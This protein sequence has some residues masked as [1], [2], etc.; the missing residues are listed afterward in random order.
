MSLTTSSLRWKRPSIEPRLLPVQVAIGAP[1]FLL[2]PA[3]FLWLSWK[4]ATVG[5]TQ[6]L[7]P[8][9]LT[10]YAAGEVVF[11]LYLLFRWYTQR[12]V[13]SGLGPRLSVNELTTLLE[14]IFA[15]PCLGTE[16]HDAVQD[17][18]VGALDD[19]PA[20]FRDRFR[21]WFLN[22]PFDKIRRGN[23]ADWLAW[24]AFNTHPPDVT[25][26]QTAVI[27]SL[28]GMF[29]K[30]CRR[31]FPS[32]QNPKVRS[33]R[34]TLDP[35][36]FLPRP[37]LFYAVVWLF[38]MQM[39][40]S[41]LRAGWRHHRIEAEGNTFSYW[42]YAPVLADG[43]TRRRPL[44][45]LHG[46]GLGLAQYGSFLTSLRDDHPDREI[47]ALVQGQVGMSPAHRHWC[48]PPTMSQTCAAI[49]RL[50]ERHD[51]H[52]VGATVLSHSFG[53]ITHAWLL[54]D[55][56]TR[57]L[58]RKNVMVDPICFRLWEAD[59]CYNF[60]YRKPQT[61]TQYLTLA[62]VARELG[63]ST[64]MYRSF[65]W[66]ENLLIADQVRDAIEAA[67]QADLHHLVTGALRDRPAQPSVGDG[68]GVKCPSLTYSS[69]SESEAESDGDMTRIGSEVD[70]KTLTDSDAGGPATATSAA[71]ESGRRRRGGG[72]GVPADRLTVFLAGKDE[73]VNAP[74][75]RDYLELER[76]PYRYYPHHGHGKLLAEHFKALD[77]DGNE[78][79]GDRAV[80]AAI[81]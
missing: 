32:G 39:R 57:H 54:K 64:A 6:L 53:T 29:E 74:A 33:I 56:S 31:K 48:R 44:L 26:E 40:L 76:I 55:A 12:K 19:E 18:N 20:I 52:D 81:A 47:V 2:Q 72:G 37:M 49:T 46:L 41:L 67:Q 38:N 5:V 7:Q 78:M 58:C 73:I 30:R 11:G 45:F 42:R 71:V 14:G 8:T 21:L 59:V 15:V 43:A 80:R 24:S 17:T 61:V 13:V 70:L 75:V 4:C 69:A 10:I 34:L 23:V 60:L 65:W 27:D 79:Y 16:N 36:P 22:A 50:S 68:G 51:L 9:F 63:V 1:L 66:A 62:V 77:S 35:I 3:C 25:P 28:I